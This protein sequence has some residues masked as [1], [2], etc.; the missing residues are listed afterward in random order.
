MVTLL[1]DLCQNTPGETHIPQLPESNNH[2]PP[3][4]N[5]LFFI[6]TFFNICPQ[7][8]PMDAYLMSS[9]INKLI[10]ATPFPIKGNQFREGTFITAAHVTCSDSLNPLIPRSDSHE[11]SP[12]NTHRLSSK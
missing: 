9:C 11:T 10:T 5:I 12:Y 7:E 1:R 4:D 8:I 6:E 3:N 2:F